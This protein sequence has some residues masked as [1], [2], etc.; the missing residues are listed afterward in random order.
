MKDRI[1]RGAAIE[2]WVIPFAAY[3]AAETPD[4]F[5]WAEQPRKLSV[6]WRDLNLI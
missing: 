3:N 4:A 2:D 1:A 6:R 5:Q